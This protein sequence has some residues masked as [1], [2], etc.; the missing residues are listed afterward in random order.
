MNA[1]ARLLRN[2]SVALAPT[3]DAYLAYD[4]DS[5]RLHRLNPAAALLIELCDGTRTADDLVAQVAPFM[6][7]DAEAGCRSWIAS[8]VDSGLVKAVAGSVVPDGPPIES[9]SS[10]APT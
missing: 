4:I 5:A 10:L 7:G 8:A 9:F 6:E 1:D 3:E 2:P